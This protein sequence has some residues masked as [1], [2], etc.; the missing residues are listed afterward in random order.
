MNKTNYL[1]FFNS[2][3]FVFSFVGVN[4]FFMASHVLAM[5][6]SCVNPFIYGI[7]NVSIFKSFLIASIKGKSNSKDDPQLN[8]ATN[9]T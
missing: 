4:Y 5:S 1:Q 6:N 9:L 8:Q 3:P 2:T 7:Y